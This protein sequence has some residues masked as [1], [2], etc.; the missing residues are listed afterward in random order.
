M[1]KDSG[2]S[3][4]QP[5]SSGKDH[6]ANCVG[7]VQEGSPEVRGSSW[8][9]SDQTS[10]YGDISVIY[11]SGVEGC[12][13]GRAGR[14]VASPANDARS[15]KNVMTIQV[16]CIMAGQGSKIFQTNHTAIH[17]IIGRN[18][19]YLHLHFPVLVSHTLLLINWG[20]WQFIYGCFSI[21]TSFPGNSSTV[22]HY[23]GYSV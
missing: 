8:H 21:W 19:A 14:V 11:L 6:A 20:N 13:A 7:V 15:A 1:R 17:T 4:D 22:I 18:R 10:G 12:P 2:K 23:C 3:G 5:T 9:C 16:D